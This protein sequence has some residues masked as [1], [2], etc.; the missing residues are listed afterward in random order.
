MT[1]TIEGAQGTYEADIN[2]KKCK[3]INFARHQAATKTV[4]NFLRFQK[5]SYNFPIVQPLYQY[6]ANPTLLP[7]DI[8]YDLSL[9]YEPRGK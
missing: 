8:I 3:L 4:S 6:I 9:I 2:G 7:E 5:Y 1:F